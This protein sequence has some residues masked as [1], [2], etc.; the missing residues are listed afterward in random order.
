MENVKLILLVITALCIV[1]AIINANMLDAKLQ[2]WRIKRKNR[3]TGWD[4][5]AIVENAR[6]RQK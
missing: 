4:I 6:R 2:Q 5:Y 1:M 3:R